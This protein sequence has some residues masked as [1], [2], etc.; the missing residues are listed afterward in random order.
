MG[1]THEFPEREMTLKTTQ[2]RDAITFAL[3]VGT[4]AAAGTG[5]AFAQE[6][7]KATT[8]VRLLKLLQAP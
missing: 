1:S 3:A 6:G 8:L 2:L 4:T 7:E 5:I